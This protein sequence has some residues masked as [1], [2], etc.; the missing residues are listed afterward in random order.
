MDFHYLLAIFISLGI[1]VAADDPL[2]T[3][4]HGGQLR[5]KSFNYNGA[6]IEIFLG[7][8]KA[9]SICEHFAFIAEATMTSGKVLK[10]E[11]ATCF[12]T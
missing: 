11:Q 3:L 2:V 1:V 6:N 4:S 9:K 10:A 8:S 7:K 12:N 5:G